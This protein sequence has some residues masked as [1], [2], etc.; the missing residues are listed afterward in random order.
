V[1]AFA[2]DFQSAQ[3]AHRDG[4]LDEAGELYKACL[5]RN[6]GD[7]DALHF[8]GLLSFQQGRSA[9]GISAV[10]ASLD[11]APDNPHAWNN[12]GNMLAG[13]SSTEAIA[14]YDR[15][16]QL[17]PTLVQAWYNLGVLHRRVRNIEAAVLAFCKA[18]ELQPSDSVVYERFGMMLYS[19]GRFPEAAG[20]YRNWLQVEPGHPVAR[21]MLAAMTGEDVPERAQDSYVTQ[22]FDR[23]SSSFDEQLRVLEYRAPELL[24]AALIAELPARARVDILDAGCGTGLCGPLLRSAASRLVGVDLSDGMIGKAAQRGVYDALHVAELT[25]FMQAQPGSFDAIVSADTLVYFGALESVVDAAARCLRPGGLFALTLERRSGEGPDYR[26]ETHG[27][28]SH[29][30]SYAVRTLQQCGFDLLEQRDVVLRKEMLADVQGLLLV[31][32]SPSRDATGPGLHRQ[33]GS[34]T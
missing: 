26:M 14:A 34:G 21:H 24:A 9:E 4:R 16:V 15:A 11:F 17:A 19:L 27:R 25:A 8:S 28:Y 12:L 10:R 7:P 5:D 18:V 2:K 1:E 31:A 13:G 30:G 32:R 29:L 20:V 23:F 33:Y 3:A 22:L 6:P